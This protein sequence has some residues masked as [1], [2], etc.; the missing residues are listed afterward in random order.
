MK[1]ALRSFQGVGESAQHRGIKT[2]SVIGSLY[3]VCLHG[4]DRGFAA[5]ATTGSH[6]KVASTMLWLNRSASQFY[7]HDVATGILVLRLAVLNRHDLLRTLNQ[8]LGEEETSRQFKVVSGGAHGHAEGGSTETNLKGLFDNEVVLYPADLSVP[9]F[10]DLC[11]IQAPGYMQH[12]SLFG[13]RRVLF[14]ADG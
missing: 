13:S 5:N 11:R 6:E 7:F 8:A 12:G 14:S 4:F 9:P 3:A 2:E 1:D 10:G